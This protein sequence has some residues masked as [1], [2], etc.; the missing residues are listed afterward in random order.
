MQVPS[1]LSWKTP[2]VIDSGAILLK[3][4]MILQF[5]VYFFFLLFF[6]SWSLPSVV[7]SM[8]ISNHVKKKKEEKKWLF[9]TWGVRD[10][11]GKCSSLLWR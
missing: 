2:R 10:E 9:V 3:M 4:M 11:H 1:D 5:K 8:N 7:I 6:I